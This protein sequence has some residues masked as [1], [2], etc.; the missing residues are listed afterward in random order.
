[1][2]V[3][4]VTRDTLLIMIHYVRAEAD[5][6]FR[7]A[8]CVW[9]MVQQQFLSS[10]CTKVTYF[11]GQYC[12]SVIIA[13]CWCVEV[14]FIIL[15]WHPCFC[16]FI[17]FLVDCV[18][19]FPDGVLHCAWCIVMSYPVCACRVVTASY[20]LHPEMFFAGEVTG[21]FGNRMCACVPDIFASMQPRR[22]WYRVTVKTFSRKVKKITQTAP[23][24][25][26][27]STVTAKLMACFVWKTGTILFPSLPH[28]KS[29]QQLCNSALPT[30]VCE[31]SHIMFSAGL[32]A[33]HYSLL[34][35]QSLGKRLDGTSC[36]T[37][38]SLKSNSQKNKC[39]LQKCICLG[40]YKKIRFNEIYWKKKKQKQMFTALRVFV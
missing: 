32:I 18:G 13:G 4:D 19:H 11:S 10:F 25:W 6:S 21:L 35:D 20:L 40:L 24:Q 17:T 7:G 36:S 34:C 22:V 15:S 38:I 37:G 23:L 30:P 2:T 5:K 1:M 14:E 8:L 16:D 27:I 31:L 29:P 39:L 33:K 12:T 9:E 28:I 3:H 26:Y